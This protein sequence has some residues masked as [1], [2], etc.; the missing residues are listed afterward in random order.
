MLLKDKVPWRQPQGVKAV[1]EVS[2]ME[3]FHKEDHLQQWKLL[4][5]DKGEAYIDYLISL[6]TK[7]QC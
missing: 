1:H 2:R 4:C 6:S 5:G 3:W 7:A